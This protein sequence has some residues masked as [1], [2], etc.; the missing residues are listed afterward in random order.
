MAEGVKKCEMMITRG[1]EIDVESDVV[2]GL[3]VADAEGAEEV[4]G[5]AL[6]LRMGGLNEVEDKGDARRE[7]VGLHELH[8]RSFVLCVALDH[9]DHFSKDE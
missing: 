2:R 4:H 1:V 9:E 6:V 7:I 8:V 3:D 5:E